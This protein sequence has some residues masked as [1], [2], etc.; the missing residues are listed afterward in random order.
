MK[1]KFGKIDVLINNA[2]VCDDNLIWDM[3]L[4]QWSR[5]MDINLGGVFLCCKIFSQIMREQNYG[6]IINISSLM[7]SIGSADQINYATSKGGVIG[8]TK[9]L[10]KDLCR[11][12]ISV[13]AISP[14][15]IQTDMNKHS[16]LK[17]KKSKAASLMDHQ[18]SLQ[19]LINFIVFLASDNIRGISGQLF[20]LDSRIQ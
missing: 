16:I 4:E 1:N 13:N 15:F 19:D 7:G 8:F 20:N 9:S 18:S 3:K 5:V 12:N 10:A 17:L 11:Y 2:G 6:K 14:G